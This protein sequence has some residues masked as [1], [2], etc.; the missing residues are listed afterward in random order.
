M[1]RSIGLFSTSDQSQLEAQTYFVVLVEG[2]LSRGHVASFLDY[3]STYIT[4][5]SKK[6]QHHTLR[7]SDGVYI[8]V[9]L[10]FLFPSMELAL[11]SCAQS[12]NS[13]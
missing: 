4:A 6:I 3:K 5:N 1:K 7:L 2:D 8:T 11:T 10:S 13:A 12:V 9:I